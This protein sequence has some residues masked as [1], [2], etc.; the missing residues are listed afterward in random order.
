MKQI[1]ESERICFTEVSED[2]IHD[3][4]IM[5][6]DHENV[7]RFIGGMNKTYTE[8]QEKEW[9]RKKL[10]EKASVFSMIEKETGEFI[11]NIE[12]IDI[13]DGQGELG[14]ALTAKRQDMGYG[15]EAIAAMINH[16]REKLGLE[17]IVLRAKPYNFRAIHVYEICGFREYDRNEEHVFME[18]T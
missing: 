4:L 10:E 15:R 8:D 13:D 7:S 3:Y 18:L 5:V 17:K 1:F 14:I 9:V 12:F 2:L 6:N 11:G 16:G